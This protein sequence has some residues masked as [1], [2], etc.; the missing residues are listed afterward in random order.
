[1]ECSFLVDILK[2]S[3][4]LNVSPQ[5]IGRLNFTQT[6][7]HFSTILYAGI[8]RQAGSPPEGFQVCLPLSVME[9]SNTYLRKTAADFS[10]VQ[11]TYTEIK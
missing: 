5:K 9:N 1:M 2:E 10:I 3:A 11:E 8:G 7:R 6:Q 4:L